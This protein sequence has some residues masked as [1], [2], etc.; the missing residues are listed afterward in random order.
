MGPLD[1]DRRP[2]GA[3]ISIGEAFA[4]LD[5]AQLVTESELCGLDACLG[6]KLASD[7]SA[8]LTLPPYDI[9]AMDGYAVALSDTEK[10]GAKLKLIGEAPAGAPFEGVLGPGQAVRIFTGGAIPDGAD[11]ILIQEHARKDGDAVIVGKAQTS[12]RH[13]RG[14]GHDFSK[15]EKLLSAGAQLG[16]REISVAA[17]GDH[18]SLPVHRKPRI[19]IIAN[20]DE[21]RAPGDDPN[22]GHIVSSNP[23]ALSALVR[24]W[25]ADPLPLGIARDSVASITA[26]IDKA[27]DADII[28]PI[29]GASV[30]D[31]DHMRNA[32]KSRGLKIVFEKIAV[33]PGKPTWFGRLGEQRVLGLPGN[34][35]SAYVCA[36]LFLK[37]LLG[38]DDNAPI[39]AILE[40]PLPTGGD[41]DAYLRAECRD[42]PGGRS[43]RP[44][45][46]Q[47]SSFVTPFLTANCLIHRPPGAAEAQTGDT[48]PIVPLTAAM[49]R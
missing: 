5:A 35:A 36:H 39:S 8:K 44:I 19:A 16:P 21:L 13:V 37:R 32:F 28:V 17:A 46:R 18:A 9:S 7:V 12:K 31:H 47:D 15:G 45:N 11:H 6:R 40:E 42:L 4:A 30:G 48:V 41:R 29:G 33:K 49:A 22:S 34:P 1:S 23:A 10:A 14:A 43:V 25:G 26:L 2:A 20:G 3:L 38:V 24:L 27:Q